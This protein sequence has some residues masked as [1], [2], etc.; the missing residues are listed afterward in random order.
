MAKL[1]RR[2]R[3]LSDFL[4]LELGA[5][6][7]M[8]CL[9]LGAAQF[10]GNVIRRPSVTVYLSFAAAQIIQELFQDS[11]KRIFARYE[12]RAEVTIKQL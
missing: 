10:S 7:M 6:T 5:Y 1:F 11:G 3:R 9:G 8:F 2:L 4:T 12:R